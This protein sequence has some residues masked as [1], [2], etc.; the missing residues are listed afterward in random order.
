VL[1][2]LVGLGDVV[3]N[4]I[5]NRVDWAL[6]WLAIGLVGS[7]L[8]LVCGLRGTRDARAIEPTVEAMISL[9]DAQTDAIC[10]QQSEIANLRA[11]LI[12]P[13]AQTT[14][15]ALANHAMLDLSGVVERL[16]QAE[17][18]LRML[19]QPAPGSDECAG[20]QRRHRRKSRPLAAGQERPPSK[21]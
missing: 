21:D 13:P 1:L 4:L 20:W 15:K 3:L 9:M 18:S 14:Q 11:T 19:P 5:L 7:Q 2:A 8:L 6:V 17:A 16:A 10:A 12:A